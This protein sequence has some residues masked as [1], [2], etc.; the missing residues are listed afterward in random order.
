MKTTSKTGAWKWLVGGLLA[1]PAAAQAQAFTDLG[2][3][4]GGSANAQDLN[5]LGQVVGGSAVVGGDE[6]AYRYH[7]GVMTDLGF[8]G[9]SGG[10]PEFNRTYTINRYC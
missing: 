5:S 2:D 8:L 1:T 10:A 3:L 7:N 6:H 4:G 9:A